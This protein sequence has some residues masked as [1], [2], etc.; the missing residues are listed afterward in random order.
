MR[1]SLLCTLFGV[2]REQWV[3]PFPA[4]ATAG[5][6]DDGAARLLAA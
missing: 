5:G 4:A 1:A 2:E 3:W 6:R